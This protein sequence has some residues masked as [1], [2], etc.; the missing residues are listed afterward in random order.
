MKKT[1]LL[2]ITGVFAAMTCGLTF[3]VRIPTPLGYTHL[4]DGVIYLAACILPSPYAL[5][6]AAIGGGLAD[7]LAG[8]PQWVIPT[9]IIKA[10]ISLPYSSK[11]VKLLTKRNALAVILSGLITIGGYFWAT[12]FMYDWAAALAEFVGNTVQAVISGVIFI[13]ISIALDEIGFKK[14]IS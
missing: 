10:L 7:L 14:R 5:L 4:G 12:W 11:S 1:R 3:F 13:S 6:A 9:L 2:V 8:F